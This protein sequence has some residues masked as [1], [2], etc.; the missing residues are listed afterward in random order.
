LP[1]NIELADT[2]FYKVGPIDMLIGAEYFFDLL[3][4]GKTELGADQLVL[5]NTKLGWIIA[6][7]VPLT[8]CEGFQREPISS[9]ICLLESSSVLSDS[10]ERFW[11]LENYDNIESFIVRRG[12]M[13]ATFRTND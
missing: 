13:R 2:D 8:I 7:S 3:E 6:G 4:V 9:L 5:Q 12:K 1:S 11:K 10:L